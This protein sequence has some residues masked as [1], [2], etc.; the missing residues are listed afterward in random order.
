MRGR[1]SLA[2]YQYHE[3]EERS[4][5]AGLVGCRNEFQFTDTAKVTVFLARRLEDMF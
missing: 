5:A 1:A 2:S 4:L 3:I